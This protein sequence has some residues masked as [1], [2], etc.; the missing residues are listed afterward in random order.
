MQVLLWA[1]PGAI[2][3]QR[4]NAGILS[5]DKRLRQT[6]LPKVCSLISVAKYWWLQHVM[7]LST[8]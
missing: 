4:M 3:E 5:V 6:D 2:A 8:I 1:D 7:H